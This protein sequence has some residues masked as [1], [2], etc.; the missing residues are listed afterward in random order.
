M[1]SAAFFAFALLLSGL[2]FFKNGLSD[3]GIWIMLAVLTLSAIPWYFGTRDR[4]AEPSLA[5]R[6][7][8]TAW[9]WFRRIL[10]VSM[11]AIFIFGGAYSSLSKA[12]SSVLSYQW[13]SSGLL[14]LLGIFLLYFGIFG[15]GANRYDWSDDVAL[16][17]E[18]KRRYCWW[19]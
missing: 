4:A 17:Q 7:F 3:A 14:V 9:V 13:I 11:G 12:S 2:F 1:T 8:A 18:N 16:H 6:V 19:F 15:Q 10:G 5:E